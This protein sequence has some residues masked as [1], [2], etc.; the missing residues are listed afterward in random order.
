MLPVV[1]VHCRGCGANE[2]CTADDDCIDGHECIRD[3]CAVPDLDGDGMSTADGDC[4]DAD[5]TVYRGAPELYDGKD[6]N[7]D[8]SAADGVYTVGAV[9][10]NASKTEW[11]FDRFIVT[12]STMLFTQTN[13]VSIFAIG[14]VI[15]QGNINLAGGEGRPSLQ[16]YVYSDV[17]GGVA[18]RTA[19]NRRGGIGPGGC[20]SACCVGAYSG[21]LVI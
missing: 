19:M 1:Q 9:G 14:D 13:P 10:Q 16:A 15:I 12:E 5:P 3:V 2:S 4:D 18:A 8:G 17:A 21:E 11:E 7:C 20:I 6:N